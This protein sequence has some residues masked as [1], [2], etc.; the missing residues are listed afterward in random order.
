MQALAQLGVLRG[1]EL[2]TVKVQGE[3]E[4]AHR[5]RGEARSVLDLAWHA[6][7]GAGAVAVMAVDDRAIGGRWC[8]RS[9]LRAAA[10]NATP[11]GTLPATNRKA[12]R[13]WKNSAT[14]ILVTSRMMP[15]AWSALES[16]GGPLYRR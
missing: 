5:L 10:S 14:A 13:M 16:P 1:C 6:Q 11:A 9:H 12:P 2:A 15:G 7:L 4:V 8:W 3:R